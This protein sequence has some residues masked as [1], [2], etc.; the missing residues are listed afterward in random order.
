MLAPK[1]EEHEVENITERNMGWDLY[2]QPVQISGNLVMVKWASV[3]W[4]KIAFSSGLQ[5]LERPLRQD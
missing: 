4:V 5:F 2:V 1:L 3:G